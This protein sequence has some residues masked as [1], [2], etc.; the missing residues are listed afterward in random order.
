MRISGI[1]FTILFLIP[2]FIASAQTANEVKA[3]FD[4]KEYIKVLEILPKAMKLKPKDA[5]LNLYKALSLYE[6]GAKSNA[7]SDF[8]VAARANLAPAFYYLGTMEYYNYQFDKSIADLNRYLAHPKADTVLKSKAQQ[9]LKYAEVANRLMKGVEK[10]QVV[11][12]VVVDKTNFINQYHLSPEAGSVQSSHNVFQHDTTSFTTL[13][14]NERNDRLIFAKKTEDQ[15]L[16]LFTKS[17]LIEKWSERT[18]LGN[19]VNSPYDENYPF[20]LSDGVTLYFSSN[21]TGSMGG[22]DIFVT[23][24][25]LSNDSY[26]MP[27][28][29]G[30][31]FNSIYNDYL[32]AIDET[33]NVG[34][35][36][37]DRYQP[38]GKVVV[39]LFIP[40][41]EKQNVSNVSPQRLIQLATLQSIK[42]TWQKGA[43]YAP[44]LQK[45]RQLKNDSTATASDFNQ[46]RFVINNEVVYRSLAQFKNADA[47]DKFLQLQGMD[48]DLYLSEGQL[49]KYRFEY[50]KALKERKSE[51]A[52][53][54]IPLESK[55]EAT[56]SKINDL[57][58][59]IRQLENLTTK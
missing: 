41:E 33:N 21:R 57:V 40:N 9:L 17:K 43:N 25:N 27:E 1:K 5:N 24:Y 15:G 49:N 51:L 7:E 12:S 44:V 2:T 4:K 34:W 28:N 42:L 22:H 30:M 59:K 39:Y 31:P 50:G 26:L 52:K 45:I 3:L 8:V 35:F 38:A 58:I 48:S 23:R 20:M 47:R 36:A 55:V 32:L 29:V 6:T 14:E 13:F 16:D 46:I 54:I 56:R 18:N 10:V 11:D 19:V 53:L 37:S